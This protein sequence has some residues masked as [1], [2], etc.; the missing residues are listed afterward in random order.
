MTAKAFTEITSASALLN[1]TDDLRC[2]HRCAGEAVRVGSPYGAAGTSRPALVQSRGDSM[3][4]VLVPLAVVLALISGV[5]LEATRTLVFSP[6]V[7]RDGG[8]EA[9]VE[10]DLVRRIY[11]AVNATI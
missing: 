3:R 10:A 7:I 5:V 8:G 4:R 6:T 9:R 11:D 2:F 1:S